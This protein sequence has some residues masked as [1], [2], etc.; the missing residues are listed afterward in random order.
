MFSHKLSII[1]LVLIVAIFLT[2][3]GNV[4]FFSKILDTSLSENLGYVASLFIWLFVVLSTILLLISNQYSAKPILIIILF[5]SAMVSYFTNNYGTIFDENMIANTMGTN[6]AESIGLLSFKLLLYVVILGIIPSYWVYKVETVHHQLPQELWRRFKVFLSLIIV[7]V[8]IT[9]VFFKSYTALFKEYA[10]LRLYINPTYHLYAIGQTINSQFKTQRMP[11]KVIGEDARI[12]RDSQHKKLVIMIAG[13]TARADRFSLNGYQRLTNPLLT[14]ESVLSFSQMSSCGTDTAYSL[15]CMF[16]SL[17]RSDYSHT[18]GKNMSNILDILNHAGVE[19]LWRD[20]NS[21]SKGVANRVTYQDFKTSSNNPMCDVECRDVGMLDGL[22]DY[23]STHKNQDILVVLHMM[24]SHGPAYYKRYPK[25]FEKFTP[26]CKTNQFSKCTDEMINN[27]YDN[28]I[29][30]T[31]YFLSQV[32]ALLKKNQTHQSAM[33]Y[34]S[35]HGE[36]L[37]EKE[38]YLHGMP[39]FI[40]PKEQTHV[41]SIAW[42]DKKFSTEVTKGKKD[43]ALSHDGLFHTLLGLFDVRTKVYEQKLDFI[44]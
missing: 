6:W 14:K 16:S 12:D 9:L 13:E 37:G 36:S 43:L 18:Q 17:G 23:I 33:L 11:F 29:V 2:I 28:T 32:I 42:F 5:S 20:N 44:R 15:P 24:G 25:A 26:T 35:D 39:Y 8:V 40:A 10:Y 38:L 1:S 41:A 19:V 3:T 7:F 22:Q 21:S 27:A 30:Y 4:V 31:D 34:M